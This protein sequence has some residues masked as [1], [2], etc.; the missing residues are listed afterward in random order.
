MAKKTEAQEIAPAVQPEITPADFTDPVPVSPAGNGVV[1]LSQVLAAIQA[2]AEQQ[3]ALLAQMQQR[4][5]DL[6]SREAELR[7]EIDRLQELMKP[8]ALF[9]PVVDGPKDRTSSFNV[10]IVPLAESGPAVHPN[11]PRWRV[12]V[13]DAPSWVVAAPDAANAFEA[14]KAA[15]GIISTPH[16]PE[17]KRSELPVGRLPANA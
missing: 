9:V 8:T 17:I 14:Y 11:W 1:D 3:Q 10:P 2:Q 15:A 13:K 4:E 5:S 6:A 16:R 12:D 7:R